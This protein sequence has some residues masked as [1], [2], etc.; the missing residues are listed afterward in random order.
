MIVRGCP[1][2]RVPLLWRLT[3]GVEKARFSETSVF[4]SSIMKTSS[5]HYGASDL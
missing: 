5:F 4:E 2:Y 1:V 3:K